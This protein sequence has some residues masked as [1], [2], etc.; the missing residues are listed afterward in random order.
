[1]NDEQRFWITVLQ[2]DPTLGAYIILPE[3]LLGSLG[4]DENTEIQYSPSTDIPKGLVVER[5]PDTKKNEQE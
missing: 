2:G 3:D 5:A 4:W 1:M